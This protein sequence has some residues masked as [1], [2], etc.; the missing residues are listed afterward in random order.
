PPP[1]I[2]KSNT[3]GRRPCTNG[4]LRSSMKRNLFTLPAL[5]LFVPV[6]TGGTAAADDNRLTAVPF[7]FVGT[8]ADCAPSA[9]G[10]QIVTAAWLAGMGLPDNG[11][12][13]NGAPGPAND[14]QFGLLRSKNCLTTHRLAPDALIRGAARMA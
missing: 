3:H 12:S 9:A 4:D 1:F 7:T 14:P 5:A 10:S 8:S 2:V 6:A 11:T 13:L